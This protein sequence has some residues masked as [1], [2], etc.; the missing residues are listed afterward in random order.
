MVM[1]PLTKDFKEFLQLLNSEQIEYLLIG[2]Y[3][4]GLYGYVRLTK[5]MD[6]WVAVHP[7]NVERLRIVLIKFAFT[8]DSLPVPLFDPVKTTLRM[9]VPP[10]QLEIL[11][12]ISGV[13]FDECY[14]RRRLITHDGVEISVISLED[15]KR[16]RL[17]TG[18]LADQ[19]DVQ[20][21]EQRVNSV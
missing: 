16:N 1:P 5:D 10:D 19:A 12:K 18:R 20:K 6:V 9:G 13:G 14:K 15:L 17:S 4:V 21:L 11:S 2:G 8:P 3:A 7:L